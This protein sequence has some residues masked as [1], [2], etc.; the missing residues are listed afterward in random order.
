[1]QRDEEENQVQQEA[2]TAGPKIKM[3]KIGGRKPRKGEPTKAA[4]APG[5]KADMGAQ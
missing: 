1:M 2:D 4:A 3:N 5:A